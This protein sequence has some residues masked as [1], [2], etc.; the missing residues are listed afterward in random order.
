MARR[1]KYITRVIVDDPMMA[2][3]AQ[4]AHAAADLVKKGWVRGSFAANTYGRKASPMAIDATSF[5]LEGAL[6]NASSKKYKFTK[7]EYQE[8][9]SGPLKQWMVG[10]AL[11]SPK[12][13]PQTWNDHECLD[14]QDC[15]DLLR[16][17]ARSQSE[18]YARYHGYFLAQKKT[19]TA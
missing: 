9:I 6:I 5:S 17:F 8:H 3:V 16:A 1:K 4:A 14:A 2:R 12:E 11:I 7:E 15:I 18:K 13:R 10:K 19:P